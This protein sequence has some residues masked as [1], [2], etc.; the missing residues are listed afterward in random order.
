MGN[1]GYTAEGARCE[2]AAELRPLCAASLWGHEVPACA[3]LFPRSV[4]TALIHSC[5]PTLLHSHLSTFRFANFVPPW[6]YCNAP[7]VSG[8]WLF[9]REDGLGLMDVARLGLMDVARLGLMDVARLGL[10]DVARLGLMDVAR[11]GLMDVA[12]LGLMDVARL[13]LMDVARLG[14][15]DVARLG[16]M[17]VARL[18]LMDVAPVSVPEGRWTGTDGCCSCQ[19][20]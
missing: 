19:C 5:T 15:M 10:M 17:D 8:V 6:R 16:L 4:V 2:G 3:L 12:R 9:S 14:L 18:G 20:S 1:T 7:H 13:G 11:L